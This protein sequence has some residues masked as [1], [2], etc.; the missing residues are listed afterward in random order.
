MRGEKEGKGRARK[1]E[2]KE[3]KERE[4][5]TKTNG[6]LN[7][8]QAEPY[9]GAASDLPSRSL[10]AP[11]TPPSFP[12]PTPAGCVPLDVLLSTCASGAANVP[13]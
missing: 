10:P 8:F 7:S 5:G 2:E 13:P 4:G 12:P 1:E 9:N 3:E 11:L 6:L